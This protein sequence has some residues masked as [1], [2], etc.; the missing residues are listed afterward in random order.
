[1]ELDMELDAEDLADRIPP[2]FR[3]ADD[4]TKIQAAI[5]IQNW[6]SSDE[7]IFHISGKLGS[8]K[9]TLMKYLCNNDTT[10]SLLD[11]WAGMCSQTLR[12]NS[13]T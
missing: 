12:S 10:R 11:T 6:L 7:G 4:E 3:S 5:K 1:M 8:G 9:S 2:N 13:H